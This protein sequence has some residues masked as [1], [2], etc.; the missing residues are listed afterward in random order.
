MNNLTNEEDPYSLERFPKKFAVKIGKQIYNARQMLRAYRH[1]GM[2]RDMY[3]Q[4]VD[5]ETVHEML[6]KTGL[7]D[8]KTLPPHL[9]EQLLTQA[10]RSGLTDA[11]VD[12]HIKY[13][14]KTAVTKLRREAARELRKRQGLRVYNHHPQQP[15]G[16]PRRDTSSLRRELF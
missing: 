1:S 3:R 7:V 9:R 16:P 14:T 5:R 13:L 2:M 8:A 6:I 11:D 4:P 10:K 12:E 15:N